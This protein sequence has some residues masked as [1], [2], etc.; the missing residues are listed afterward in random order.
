MKREYIS[1]YFPYTDDKGKQ[2]KKNLCIAFN[3]KEV[4]LYK[5]MKK[6]GSSEIKKAIAIHSYTHLLKL[7]EK[8]KRKPTE[9]VK[10][11]Y[12]DKLNNIKTITVEIDPEKIKKWVSS[13]KK[14]NKK[15]MNKDIRKFM[16]GLIK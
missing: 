4:N 9:F 6:S 15:G 16:E 3:Q 1:I 14:E 11:M 7:A 13:L 12:Q 8:G 5:K 10:N 2:K